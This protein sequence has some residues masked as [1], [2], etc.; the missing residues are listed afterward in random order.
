MAEAVKAEFLH[1]WQGYLAHA[2]GMDALRPLSSTGRNRYDVSLLMT[3]L[4]AFDTM[5][6][7]GLLNEAEEAKEM[8][9]NGLSFNHDFEV[10]VFEVT[11]RIL[12]GLIT[13][14]QMDGDPRFLALATD[15]ANRLLPAFESGTGMPYRMVNLRTG[16]RSGRVNNP[17]EIGT[18]TVEFGALSRITG[19]PDYYDKVKA[20]VSAIFRRRSDIGLVGTSID[21]ETGEWR[22]PSSHISGMIDSYYEYL[23]KSWVLFDDP[24]FRDMWRTSAESV[25]EFLAHEVDGRL[26]Y[27]RADMNTGERTETSF[28]ALDAFWPGV[29]ALSGDMERA[30]RLMESVHSMWTTFGVEPEQMDYTTMQ[31]L[32]GGYPLRPEALESAYV[33]YTL[34]EDPGYRTMGWDIFQRIV[35]WCRTES[36]YAHLADVRTK[37]QADAMESFFLAETLKYAYLLFAPA[38]TLPFQEVVFNTEAH[39]IRRTWE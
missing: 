11:I 9:L 8:I 24:E 18:L 38:E 31:V 34:T 27:G 3:P 12:G 4:D 35:R 32:S 16:E 6:L 17:A 26:W 14:Y 33:L 19:N 1:A 36:G 39:P 7:I 13:A 2:R 10:L 23:L 37:E 20:G 25:N 29:L 5:P 22:N 30:P 28:G 15:L 21:V